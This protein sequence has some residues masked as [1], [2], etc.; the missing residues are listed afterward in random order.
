MFSID[1]AEE[2]T[3]VYETPLQFARRRHILRQLVHRPSCTLPSPYRGHRSGS[4]EQ[5]RRSCVPV[6]D[7]VTT[8]SLVNKRML[9]G[10]STPVEAS[11]DPVGSPMDTTRVKTFDLRTLCPARQN[12]HQRRGSWVLRIQ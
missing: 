12:A 11:F 10:T 8:K 2:S 3:R 5:L 9:L 7:P 6:T 4:P 1:R